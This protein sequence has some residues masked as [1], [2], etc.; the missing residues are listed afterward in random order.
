MDTIRLTDMRFYAFHGLAPAERALGQ[1]FSVDLEVEADLRTPGQSDQLQD[2]VNYAHL[3][4]AV[5]EIMHGP[6]RNLLEAVA[7]AIVQRVLEGFPV[8][9]VRVR[10]VKLAP[11]I[12]GADVGAASVEVHR[13]RGE[14]R[15]P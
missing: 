10:V 9:S 15:A 14:A 5:R 3:Y 11:P 1:R 4:R 7:A 6:P 8:A 12:T 13:R 2:T